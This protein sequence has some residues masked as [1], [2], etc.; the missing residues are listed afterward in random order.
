MKQKIT[1]TKMLTLAVLLV[2]FTTAS[3]SFSGEE[4]CKKACCKEKSSKE[5][6]AAVAELEK[7]LQQLEVQLKTLNETKNKMQNSF[8][9]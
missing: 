5:I 7:A 9:V 1:L 2:C 8:N 3:A 4:K 6:K